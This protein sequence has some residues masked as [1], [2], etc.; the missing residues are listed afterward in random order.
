MALTVADVV[1]MSLFAQLNL[2]GLLGPLVQAQPPRF[3]VVAATGSGT[4]DV[5]WENGRLESAIPVAAVD[6]IAAPDAGVVSSLQGFV[7]KTNPSVASQAESPE[8]QGVAVTFYTRQAAGSGTVTDTLCLMKTEA[9][10]FRELLAATLT[11][12]SGR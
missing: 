7:L 2:S 9:G 12:V 6:K 3:G 8:F 5:L 11:V 1:S 4:V 10:L